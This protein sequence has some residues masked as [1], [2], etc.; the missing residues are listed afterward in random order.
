MYITIFLIVFDAQSS[1]VLFSFSLIY[2]VWMKKG[3][4]SLSRDCGFE[5]IC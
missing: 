5:L 3:H 4:F 1:Q 2:C